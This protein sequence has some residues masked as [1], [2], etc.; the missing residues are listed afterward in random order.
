[1]RSIVGSILFFLY[2]VL[3]TPLHAT[4]LLVLSPIL[5][6][7][8]RYTV[9]CYWN[10]FNIKVMRFLC[11]IEYKVEGMEHLPNTGA[12][13]LA[14]HQSAWE[15]FGIPANLLPRQLCLVYKRELQYI[16]FFGWCLWVLRMV[17][18]D[19]NKGVEAF[20][21]IRTMAGERMRQGAWMMFFPEGTR[22]PAGY[23]RR[24]KTGGTRLAVA[25]NTPVVPVAVNAGEFW[26]RRSFW[27]KPG[28][29]T[30]RFGKPIS[31]EGH[32]ADSLMA[33]VETWIETQMHQMSPHLYTSDETPMVPKG[34]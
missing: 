33:E 9:A 24:Y 1:M 19:R 12:I 21:Q 27:K 14:K 13:I 25:T 18:I 5:S 23:K 4:V 34:Q 28:L 20:D 17:P 30:L 26:G 29:V 11:G 2:A 10:L 15:T 32:D 7:K 16:P 22:V 8:Q 6:I 3:Y 31:P